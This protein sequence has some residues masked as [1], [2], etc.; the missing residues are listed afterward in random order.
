MTAHFK[1]ASANTDD[2]GEESLVKKARPSVL[3]SSVLS[4]LRVLEPVPNTELT[5]IEKSL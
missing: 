3:F 5:L 4:I 1:S 2:T